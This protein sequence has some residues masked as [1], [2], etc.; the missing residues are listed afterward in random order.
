MQAPEVQYHDNACS[1]NVVPHETCT[2]L[3]W[4]KDGITDLARALHLAGIELI[5]SGGT[6]KVLTAAGIPIKE[7]SEY[8]GF[9]R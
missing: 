4:N 9:P 8:T 3:S 5:S 6:A 7:V 2:A 1:P